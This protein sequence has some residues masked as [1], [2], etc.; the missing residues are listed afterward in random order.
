LQSNA[1]GKYEKALT[2]DLNWVNWGPYWYKDGKHI[3][4]T[5]ANHS[6]PAARPNSHLYWMNIETGKKV[7]ITYT[8]GADVLPVFSPDYKKL[9]W[10]ST[11]DGR[12]PAQLCIADLT[13]PNDDE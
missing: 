3:I 1:D 11:R 9:R 12:Q 7:R 8:P 2:D 10:T 6:N 5:G 13:P 4:N